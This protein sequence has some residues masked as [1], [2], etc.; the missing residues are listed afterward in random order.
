MT[1]LPGMSVSAKTPT[2]LNASMDSAILLK[3]LFNNVSMRLDGMS[4]DDQTLALYHNG[5]PTS[6]PPLEGLFLFALINNASSKSPNK[7]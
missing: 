4:S 1:S 7:P 3:R 5:L 2:L 6:A